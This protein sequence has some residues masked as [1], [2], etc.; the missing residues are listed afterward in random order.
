MNLTKLILFCTSFIFQIASM[1]AQVKYIDASELKLIGKLSAETETLYERL[2]SYLEGQ[3]RKPVWNL[4]KNTS[5]LAIRFRSNSSSVS[6]KWSVLNDNRMNHMTE[7]GIKGLD[8]YT[9][10]NDTWQ[11]VNSARPTAVSSEQVIISNMSPTE[12][13]Y[14]LYLPLYDGV[15]DLQIGVDSTAFIDV[16]RLS[17]PSSENPVIF[18]GTSITQGG[19]ATRPGMSYPNILNRI[20]NREI[21]NLGFSGNGQLDYEIAELMSS[22]TDAGLFVLDFIPNVSLE[23]VKEKTIIFVDKLRRQNGDIPLLFVESVL[24]THM[25]FDNQVY[26]TVSDKNRALREQ[27]DKMKSLGYENI[28][29]LPAENLIGDD[30]EATIDGVHLTDVGFMRMADVLKSQIISIIYKK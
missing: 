26:K 29:Y 6:A 22:R 25:K 30:G 10:Q 7:T 20:L 2:P 18:Y 19:C 9:W 1:H 28:Y 15:T 5:G 16:P 21:I 11:F 24:F 12:R 17:Y 27:Y 13:E 3:T 8:L 4:G 14:M 23:Q